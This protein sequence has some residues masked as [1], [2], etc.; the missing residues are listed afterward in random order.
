[1]LMGEYE[2]ELSPPESQYCLLLHGKVLCR[3]LFHEHDECRGF[4]KRDPLHF[5][6]SLPRRGIPFRLESWMEHESKQRRIVGVRQRWIRGRRCMCL[7]HRTRSPQGVICLYP[8]FLC[9]GRTDVSRLQCF[10]NMWW[11][12]SSAAAAAAEMVDA[13]EQQ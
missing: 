5:L 4:W 9:L 1:M 11:C 6:H 3:Y 2:L 8:S 13:P 7:D 10:R 12:Q